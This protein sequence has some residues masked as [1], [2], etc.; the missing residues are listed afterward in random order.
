M[1]PIKDKP[2]QKYCT[3]GVYCQVSACVHHTPENLCSA[4]RINI[5]NDKAL[6]QGETFCSTFKTSGG[7]SG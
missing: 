4:G 7:M 2:G 6:K 1:N 3:N 5:A